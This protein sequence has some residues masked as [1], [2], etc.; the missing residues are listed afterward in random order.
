MKGQ[1][2][3]KI[4]VAL[5]GNPNVGKSTLFNVLTG[6]HRHTGNWSGKTVDLASGSCR[7]GTTEFQ[8]VDL[9]GTYSLEGPA[10]EKIAAEYL[11]DENADCVVVVCDASALERNLIL[12]LEILQ[13]GLPTVLC[14]NMVDEAKKQGIAIDAQKLSE[15]LGV[16]V[17]RTVAQEKKGLDVLLNHIEDQVGKMPLLLRADW[18][19]PIAHAKV[20]ADRCVS[21]GAGEEGWR[22]VLDRILV[23]RRRGIPVMLMLLFFIL[24]LTVWGANYPA[25]WMER[26]FAWGHTQLW[27]LCGWMPRWLSGILL[28]GIYT[29]ATTVLAV[30]LPPVS[31]FFLLFTLLEDT[32]YLPRMAFLLDG[33]LC[34]CGGC[35]K[36]ALT[37][38]MGLGCNAVGVTGCRIISSPRERLLAVLTNAMIP[39]NGRFPTLIALAGLFLPAPAAAAGVALCVVLG[40]LGAMAVSGVLSKTA[41]RHEQSLF[42]MEMP[43]LRRPRLAAMLMRALWDRTLGIAL[44][45]LQVAAPAGA[46]LWLL[47]QGAI[48]PRLASVLD[49]MGEL[50]GMNG[51]L[52]L[53]FALSFPANELL[54]PTVAMILAAGGTHQGGDSVATLLCAGVTPWMA[55]CAAVFTVFHWPCGTTVLTVYKETGKLRY[56]IGAVLLPTLVGILLCML[57]NLLGYQ[58]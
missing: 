50:L 47:S 17:V 52:L 55:L 49:P 14:V 51:I 28:D 12:A 26:F 22:R 38:C 40:V 39:C 15:M 23:S 42:L 53:A 4:T 35:G 56:T 1:I 29:T 2:Q 27:A 30:M 25:A 11:M 37:M 5:A 6:R 18:D 41:L 16:P 45:A 33:C 10:E 32:G 43:P 58:S 57:L 31:I 48:L 9:P 20:L 21:Y 24:W 19:D 36:Q 8:W 13:L 3:R 7:R 46:V 34:R 54:I 44:R